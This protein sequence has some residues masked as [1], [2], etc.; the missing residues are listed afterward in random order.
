MVIGE[1]FAHLSAAAIGLFC[2]WFL[3]T[4]YLFVTPA[5]VRRL[6]RQA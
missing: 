5:V 4:A 2:V 1:Q 6:V 3:F